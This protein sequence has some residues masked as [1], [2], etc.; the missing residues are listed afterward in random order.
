MSAVKKM[1]IKTLAEEFEKL[2]EEVL[3][4]RPLK[5]KVADLEEKLNKALTDKKV[6]VEEEEPSENHLK[7]KICE[8]SL[9]S[10]NELKKH[11]KE[12]HP[13]EIKCVKCTETFTKN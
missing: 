8:R 3:E 13:K 12:K 10:V 11:I 7:C 2:K 4:L 6:N 1:T 9:P 5:K